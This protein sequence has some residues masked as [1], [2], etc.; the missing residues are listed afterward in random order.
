MDDD[1]FDYGYSGRNSKNSTSKEYD[2]INCELKD[3][4]WK[5]Y[6]LNCDFKDL[7]CDAMQLCSTGRYDNYENH[8]KLYENSNRVSSSF[9]TREHKNYAKEFTREQKEDEYESCKQRCLEEF[10]KALQ[11]RRNKFIEEVEIELENTRRKERST[12]KKSGCSSSSFNKYEGLS[13]EQLEQRMREKLS[14]LHAKTKSMKESFNKHESS[15]LFS[16]SSSTRPI[17]GG[18]SKNNVI[19]CRGKQHLRNFHSPDRVY[20]DGGKTYVVN[21]ASGGKVIFVPK[22]FEEY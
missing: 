17:G 16:S 18:G 13:S 1:S 5:I 15:N 14:A 11:S 9:A 7:K 4:A 6:D 22:T 10:E 12:Y 8:K 19:C 3:I 2:R 21:H 20:L